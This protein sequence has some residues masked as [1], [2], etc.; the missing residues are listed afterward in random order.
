MPL[1]ITKP[2]WVLHND[3]KERPVTIFTLAVHPDGSR[4]ATGGLDTKIKIWSTAPIVQEVFEK[5]EKC[6]KLL[7]TMTSHSGVVMCVRWSNSGRYLASGSDDN[8][9][10]IWNLETGSGGKVWGSTETNVEN[11]KAV[12]R[13]VGH[14]SDVSGVAWSSD[15]AYLASVGLD[16]TVLIWSGQNFELIRRLDGHEGFVKG[17]VFDPVGQYLATQ[18]RLPLNVE[19]REIANMVYL[20]KSD[21][22]SVKIWR[23]NDWGLEATIV[24]PFVNSPKTNL[25]RLTWSPEGTHVVT[26]NSMNGPVFVAAVIDRQAWASNNSMVGHE[27][28]VE[29]AA[30]NPLIF[31]RESGQPA[32]G[33]NLCTLLALSARSSISL[34]VTSQS[35]PLVVLDEVFD[36]DVLDLSWFAETLIISTSRSW[37]ITDVILRSSDGTQL[38]AC[39][40]E[41]HVAVF[42]FTLSDF[43]AVA[44]AGTKE[45]YHRTYNFNRRAPLVSRVGLTQASSSASLNGPSIGTMAQPNTLIARKGP[46]AKRRVIPTIVQPPPPRAV[47]HHQPVASTSAAIHPPMGNA[48]QPPI[49]NGVPS[50]NAAWGGA[51]VATPQMMSMHPA[52]KKRRAELVE[53]DT[54]DDTDGVD[55]YVRTSNAPYRSKGRTLGE[56]RKR[57]PKEPLR[58][59]RP[60]YLPREKERTFEISNLEKRS[61][62]GVRVLAIPAV[63]TF[64]SLKVE[65]SDEKDTLEWRN[66]GQGDKEGTSEVAVVTATKTLWVDYL[67]K[68]IVCAAG[69]PHFVA[70]STEDGSLTVYSPT[71]RRLLPTMVLDSPCSF[72]EAE[73]P[74]LLAITALG[75]LT[76]WNTSF[77]KSLFP[78]LSISTLLTSSATLNVPHPEITTAALQLNG[79]PL[80][81]LSS[82]STHSYD[83]NLSAWIRLSDVWWSKGSDFWEARRGKANPSGRG[84]IRGIES[85]IN[86]IVV[87]QASGLEPM[88]DDDD[89]DE[90][91][92]K[93]VPEGD[94]QEKIGGAEMYRAAIS[95]GHLEVRMKAAIAL[96]SPAEYRAFLNAYAKRLG[97]EGFRGKA[98]EL[99]KELLG[100][101]YYK[102]GNEKEWSPTVIGLHKRDLLKEVLT[103]F[104]KSRM[105]ATLGS[106]YQDVLRKMSAA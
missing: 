63:E 19:Q 60:A 73:G 13:L 18:V 101:V 92:E 31:L 50:A 91:V 26:P 29:V 65:D 21:D 71:G 3:D 2:A 39:S 85:A 16:S 35:Q 96:D 53:A 56:E 83:S 90:P 51:V 94:A 23:T 42:T 6:P 62:K 78:P 82:G 98:E 9:V 88:Q 75:S 93:T 48:F 80:V 77:A 84:V 76:V 1:A 102:P 97:E 58:E 10:M 47:H 55:P 43:N 99:I 38:W 69:S 24:E 64:G 5:D 8:I 36:R 103:I 22:N 70:V 89:D 34:W 30:F 66:F 27:N 33:G 32:T 104:A 100:P 79:T 44:P 28:I 61:G 81:A 105:I 87:E 20:R 72:L 17:V 11:W 74:F 14:D 4:L 12:R 25:S 46:G 7:C 86:D 41:G 106:E 40:S 57:G 59:L 54:D 68:Y 52:S 49:Q 45:A 67:P 37:L 15:D 95:L